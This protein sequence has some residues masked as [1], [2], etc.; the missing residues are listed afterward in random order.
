M[1][2]EIPFNKMSRAAAW[3][4]K[5]EYKEAS[6][7]THVVFQCSGLQCMTVSHWGN[8]A[9][10]VTRSGVVISA[11]YFARW[12]SMVML[13]QVFYFLN[14]SSLVRAVLT[15]RISLQHFIIYN[16]HWGFHSCYF[17]LRSM[18]CFKLISIEIC[19]ANNCGFF[20]DMFKSLL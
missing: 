15:V 4:L 16:F 18:I 2:K 12:M 5:K 8:W 6:F 19:V 14:Q 9:K 1:N 20:L 7:W 3:W 17:L 13:T 10:C 11:R